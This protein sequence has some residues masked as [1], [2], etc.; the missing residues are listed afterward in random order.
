MNAVV[1]QWTPVAITNLIQAKEKK[2]NDEPLAYPTRFPQ[3][4]LMTVGRKFY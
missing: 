3:H 4:F 1:T 2:R